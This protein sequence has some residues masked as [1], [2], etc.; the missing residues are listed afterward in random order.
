MAE[1]KEADEQFQ[2][3]HDTMSK[4]CDMPPD[5]RIDF[6]ISFNYGCACALVGKEKAEQF[7]RNVLNGTIT[8][9]RT[10][11]DDKSDTAH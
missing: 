8:I 1:M 10:M 2:I 5:D 3:A 6:L 7:L 11:S 9:A 4:I